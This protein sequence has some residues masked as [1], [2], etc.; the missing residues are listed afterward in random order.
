[1][2]TAASR[3]ASL[4]AA[5]DALENGGA[6]SYSIGSRSVSKLDISELYKERRELLREVDRES[7]GG[8]RLAR[9]RRAR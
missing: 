1:M 6:Q 3:L 8:F 5:I 2:A 7:N 4:E 9:M